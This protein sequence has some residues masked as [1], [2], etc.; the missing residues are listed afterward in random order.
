MDKSSVD[1]LMNFVKGDDLEYGS[2]IASKLLALGLISQVPGTRQYMIGQLASS[3]LNTAMSG[4]KRG[5]KDMLLQ[6]QAQQRAQAATTAA[7][8]DYVKAQAAQAA[9]GG[10]AAGVKTIMQ[11]GSGAKPL[12]FSPILN[13][14]KELGVDSARPAWVVF[15]KFGGA[16]RVMGLAQRAINIVFG[17]S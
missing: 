12:P 6:Y 7:Q 9:A 16:N 4:N 14:T 5:A 17:K 3:F 13:K 15:E 8:E 2:P 11:G 10:S 1:G